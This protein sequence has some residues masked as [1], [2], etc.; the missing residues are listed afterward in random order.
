MATIDLTLEKFED[1]IENNEI[2]LIDFWAE[3]CGPCKT[4][5]PVYEKASDE[6]DDVV[7]AKVDTSA[8]QQLAQLFRI[9]AI[10][11]LLAIRDEIPVFMES[12]ALPLPALR[13]LIEQVRELDMDDVRKKYEEATAES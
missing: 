2:V 13:S 5:A 11:T 3:W 7:F 6:F 12:G 4:F 8:Q 9:Q 10:P 1:T